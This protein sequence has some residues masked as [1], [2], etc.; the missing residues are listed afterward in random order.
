[1]F[2]FL[3]DDFK[4]I[5]TREELLTGESISNLDNKKENI[6]H[7]NENGI[8]K[9]EIKKECALRE[10]KNDLKKINDY[11]IP[12]DMFIID[13]KCVEMT[14][15]KQKLFVVEKE[16]YKYYITISNNKIILKQMKI[17]DSYIYEINIDIFAKD[18]FKITY[19]TH[20][21]NHS[22]DNNKRLKKFS[23]DRSKEIILVKELLTNLGKIENI[24]EIIR[25]SYIYELLGIV[26]EKFQFKVIEDDEISLYYH[27]K[28]SINT[29]KFASL[30]IAFN[31]TKEIVGTIDFNYFNPGFSYGGNI[32]YEINKNFQNRHFATKALK[33]LK[34]LLKT[35]NFKGDKDLY[36]AIL[37]DNIKSQKVACN[38]GGELIYEGKVPDSD[39]MNFIDGIKNVKVYRIKI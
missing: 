30:E 17:L 19:V 20:D 31:D 33:L 5:I 15:L 27:K 29:E 4:Y 35:N 39:S 36:L 10:C 14:F 23:L 26:N 6:V 25:L 28:D 9:V 3:M 38:N 12:I 2:D 24:N 11:Y 21:L 32:S 7:F 34:K 8:I 16:N 18:D 1:M 37:P 13:N 22:I